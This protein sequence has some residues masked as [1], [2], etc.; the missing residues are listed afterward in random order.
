MFD[1]HWFGIS[2]LMMTLFWIL[3]IILIVWIVKADSRRKVLKDT[4][5][6]E[7]ALA[8]LKERYARGEI[9]Q[10]KFRQMRE[11]ILSD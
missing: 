5:P 11:E 7:K 8:I 2:G 6:D 10:E 9:D 1:G 4:R 3:L